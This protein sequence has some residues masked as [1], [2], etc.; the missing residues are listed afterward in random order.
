MRAGIGIGSAEVGE[1]LTGLDRRDRGRDLERA[2]D[3]AGSLD[4]SNVLLDRVD[5]GKAVRGD[6]GRVLKRLLSRPKSR[7]DERFVPRSASA[8][9]TGGS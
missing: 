4:G 3:L 5:N 7:P 9:S 8:F 1:S 6:T 2:L